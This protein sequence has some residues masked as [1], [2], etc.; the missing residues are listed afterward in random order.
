MASQLQLRR[1]TTAQH[2]VFTG[3]PGE[4]TVDTTTKAL[5]V[6]DGTTVGGF[7][8]AKASDL[9]TKLSVGAA[10]GGALAGT[11]PNPTLAPITATGSTASRSLENRFAEVVNVKDFGAKGDW[12]GVTGTDD[13]AAIQAAI[14]RVVSNGGGTLQFEPGK[15]YRVNTSTVNTAH[16]QVG[17]GTHIFQIAGLSDKSSVVIDGRGATLYSSLLGPVM[18]LVVSDFK[19][20]V[21]RDLTI[22]R[23]TSVRFSGAWHMTTAFKILPI[24]ST[25]S[26]LVQFNNVTFTNCRC[27]VDCYT[28]GYF[29]LHDRFG[30][31]RLIEFQSCK[32]F[33][34]VG[35]GVPVGLG[36]GGQTVNLDAWIDTSIFNNIYW[37]GCQNGQL[38]D[39]VY[40]VDGFL[41]VNSIRTVVT[42]SVFKD[43]WVECLIADGNSAVAMGSVIGSNS[44]GSITQP[45]VGDSVTVKL[46]ADT[47]MRV[48]V[49][50]RYILSVSS[51]LETGPMGVFEVT[52]YSG[53]GIAGTPI[54]L[55]RLSDSLFNNPDLNYGNGNGLDTPSTG[56]AASFADGWAKLIDYDVASQSTATISNNIISCDKILTTSGAPWFGP[57]TDLRC[58]PGVMMKVRGSVTGNT[59]SGCGLGIHANVK[60]APA[61]IGALTI[62][63]NSIYVNTT[64][65]T[66]PCYGIW[67]NYPNTICSNNMIQVD[68]TTSVAAGVFVQSSHQTIT[69]N[70]ML[71]DNAI[72]GTQKSVFVNIINVAG[73]KTLQ[74]TLIR[75]NRIRNVDVFINTNGRTFAEDYYG[76]PLYRSHAGFYGGVRKSR[77]RFSATKNGWVR[78]KMAQSADAGTD[79]NGVITLGPLKFAFSSSPY[80]NGGLCVLQN[81]LATA[82][83]TSKT[84]ISK[85]RLMLEQGSWVDVFINDYTA[86]P[87]SVITEWILESE[88]GLHAVPYAIE[89]AT[90]TGISASGTSAVVTTSSPHGF[91]AGDK[92]FISDTNSTPNI[93]GVKTVA[94]ST[95]DTFTIDGVT[96]T[97]AGTSGYALNNDGSE[98]NIKSMIYLRQGDIFK[99]TSNGDYSGAGTP[100]VA[101]EFF[102]QGYYDSTHGKWYKAR[103]L[104]LSDWTILN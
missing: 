51:L 63:G 19:T 82:Y 38:P 28:A 96:I 101:P 32:F 11:L 86:T 100:S 71:V 95:S 50:K 102:G 94:S 78:L 8:A 18:F 2:A 34:P 104:A 66:H 23:D 70:A 88:S 15:T 93:N 37:E 84:A 14:N 49:G 24:T 56:T 72:S 5:V 74:N 21:T 97:T 58:S 22:S 52:A 44:D 60:Y 4:I 73:D 46:R 90:I 67:L 43:G 91:V 53:S 7:P 76:L 69:D 59:I 36:G 65:A 57:N 29:P 12:N 48:V 40:P 35:S 75:G 6:H 39:G 42:N 62:V 1:G 41:Y 10:V 17:S 45:A 64:L 80:F 16:W 25:K 47:P 9:A 33:H 85:I 27:A 61:P 20:I 89:S 31:L 98:A 3:A 103:G 55:K 81:A 26:E 13:T 68:K 99:A 77:G 83:S 79:Q 54:V 30:K 87:V 92:V